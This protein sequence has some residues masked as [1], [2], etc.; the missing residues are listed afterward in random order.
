MAGGGGEQGEGDEEGRLQPQLQ[1]CITVWQIPLPCDKPS[2]G[3]V[4]AQ[5]QVAQKA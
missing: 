4:L 3:L 1:C 2:A 5:K